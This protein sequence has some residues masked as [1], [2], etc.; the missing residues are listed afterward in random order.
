V[1]RR[2]QE[3]AA[4]AEPAATSAAT[5]AKSAAKAKPAATS[6]GG[7][8]R[9][10]REAEVADRGCAYL[11]SRD[12]GA[13]FA[14]GRVRQVEKRR[15]ATTKPTAAYRSLFSRTQQTAEPLA[16][17]TGLT[18]NE[19]PLSGANLATYAD[20][21]AREIR[22]H[23]GETVVVVSHSNTVPAIVSAFSGV[24][25]APSTRRPARGQPVAPRQACARV[26]PAAY[27]ITRWGLCH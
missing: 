6:A 25:A 2:A 19:R 22:G 11:A 21:L 7:G 10:L 17:A 3:T 15:G 5:K 18:I 26:P 23:R 13:P 24:A 27:S 12:R 16:Q 1:S 8:P 4:K 9:A 14:P 20:D